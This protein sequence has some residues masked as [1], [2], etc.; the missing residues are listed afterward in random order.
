MT[1]L[2]LSQKIA[3]KTDAELLAMFQS[4]ADWTAEA[5]DAAIAE[6]QKRNVNT[7]GLVS[8]APPQLDLPKRSYGVVVWAGIL[9]L[10]MFSGSAYWFQIACGVISIAACAWWFIV[11]TRCRRHGFFRR[12]LGYLSFGFGSMLPLSAALLFP[13]G[14]VSKT[15][16]DV[17]AFRF[18]IMIALAIGLIIGA[19]ALVFQ[20]AEKMVAA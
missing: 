2:E 12:L 4:P 13:L 15:P 16:S 20:R 17:V 19:F 10:S 11:S 14:V 3:E 8:V 6:L 18:L 5:L 7:D 9:L 1:T